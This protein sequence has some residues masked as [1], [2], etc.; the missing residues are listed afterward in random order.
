MG[1]H[2]RAVV[3]PELLVWARQSARY[4]VHEAAKKANVS[5]ERLA[6]WG[7]ETAAGGPRSMARYSGAS[8]PALPGVPA[9]LMSRLWAQ[10]PN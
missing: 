7:D 6:G 4:R 2:V 9:D 3:K 5:A 8:D 1:E 10:E